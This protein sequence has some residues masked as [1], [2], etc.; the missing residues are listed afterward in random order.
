MGECQG[1]EYS[2]KSTPEGRKIETTTT[3]LSKFGAQ[4]ARG[5]KVMLGLRV[6]N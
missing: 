5:Q 6:T 3:I 2:S 1:K 4:E